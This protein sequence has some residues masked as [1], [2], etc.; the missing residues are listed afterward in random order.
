MPDVRDVVRLTCMMAML[1]IAPAHAFE[2][3]RINVPAA[4]TVGKGRLSVMFWDVYDAALFAPGGQWRA[5]G[6][7]ALSL[8]YLRDIRG[9]AIADRSAEEI[10]KLGF[11]DEVTL[12]TWH[13]QM[14]GIFPDVAEGTTLTGVYT[15]DGESIFYHDDQEIGRVRDPAFGRYFFNIW[16]DPQTSAPE[17]RARLLGQR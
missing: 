8:T 5:E 7:F 10:R 14:R 1:G 3:I 4:E 11:G 13:N 15:E 17:L 12:A 16:L 9:R 6:P 2:H